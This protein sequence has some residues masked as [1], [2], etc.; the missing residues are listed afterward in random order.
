MGWGLVEEDDIETLGI[1][2]PKL[3][4]KDGEAIGIQ[5]RQLPPEGVP[6]RGFHRGIAP[7]ILVEGLN[8]LEG[9]HAVAR[10][11]TREGHVQAQTTCILAKHP[12]GVVGHLPASGGDGAQAAR[13]LFDNIRC[14]RDVG[15]AWLGRG[16][17]SVAVR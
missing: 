4:Q 8:D 14:R 2:L 3:P 11:P 9:L 12:H 17:L 15:F 13:A 6:R 16:R 7:V 1:V 10:Q 5:A